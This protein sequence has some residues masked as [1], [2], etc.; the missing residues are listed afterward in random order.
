MPLLIL[1]TCA[2]QSIFF[3]KCF[4]PHFSTARGMFA[5]LTG[6]PDAQLFKFSSRNPEAVKQHTI[7]N[8][9]ED[10]NKHYF[11]G[12]DPE[13]SNFEGLLKNING[14]QMHTRGSFKASDINVWGISD[15]DLFLEA[16]EVFKKESK[17][18]FAY[19]QTAGNHRPYDKAISPLDTTFHKVVVVDEELRKYG[20]G[21]LD[22]YNAFRYFDF[23]FE[24]F[25]EAAKK[26][27]YFN[28]TIFVFVG[29]H[30]VAGN[31][32]EIYPIIW[33]TARLTDEHVPLLFYAPQLLPKERRKEVVS[34]INIFRRSRVL[35][36]LLMKI[37][38]W[39]ETC[40]SGQEKRLRF[41]YEYRRWD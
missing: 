13:F 1:M 30:G 31:A 5:I 34:H 18:F 26:E 4:T 24:Q 29:D 10:Y 22:E 19:I 33:T 15:K 41:Y 20:F 40:R 6:I 27:P 36:I 8:S 25:L 3:E 35:F 2:S 21:S 12:G 11:L 7:I 39:V 16:N 32:K 23:C 17:P 37:L 38:P 14:L 28:N 9:F